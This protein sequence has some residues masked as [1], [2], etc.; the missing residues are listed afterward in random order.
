MP[1]AARAWRVTTS[2]AGFGFG[3]IERGGVLA[4]WYVG[5][6]RSEMRRPGEGGLQRWRGLRLW[7]GEVGVRRSIVVGF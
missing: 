3:W 5:L 2:R 6:E 7:K 4:I 1:S